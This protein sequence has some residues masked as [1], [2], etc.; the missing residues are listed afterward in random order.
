MLQEPSKVHVIP[1]PW[2]RIAHAG[3]SHRI[4]VIGYRL[5]SITNA[6]GAF[7]ALPKRGTATIPTTVITSRFETYFDR[8]FSCSNMAV[9][10]LA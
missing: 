7:V 9:R 3:V 6:N 2:V 8:L 4:R 5:K 10:A 1:V